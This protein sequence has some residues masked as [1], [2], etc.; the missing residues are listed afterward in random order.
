MKTKKKQLKIT[1]LCFNNQKYYF[2]INN[3]SEL[4]SLFLKYI[5]IPGEKAMWINDNHPELIDA[6]SYNFDKNYD[7]IENISG[8]GYYSLLNK[9]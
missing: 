5:K 9:V 6:I 8:I 7:V 1:I 2:D 4:I 3:K